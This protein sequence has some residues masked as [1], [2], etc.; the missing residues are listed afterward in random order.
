MRIRT[1]ALSVALAL[2]STTL[3]APAAHAASYTCS[4]DVAFY[5][6][7]TNAR[8]Y[9]SKTYYYAQARIDRY[10]AGSVYAYYGSWATGGTFSIASSSLGVN[11]GNAFRCKYSDPPAYY[12]SPWSWTY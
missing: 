12:I 2:A 8:I 6:T 11:A 4:F 9:P 7:Q 1:I 10:S 5:S 3:A